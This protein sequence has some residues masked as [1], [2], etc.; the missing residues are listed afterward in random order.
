MNNFNFYNPTKIVFGKDTI[1]TI[2]REIKSYDLK[3]I[4]ILAG[5]GSIKENGVYKEVI[6]ALKNEQIEWLELWG[7]Q[8]NPVMS[9]TL[10]AIEIAKINHAEAVLAIGG[11]SVI[12]EAKAIA[13]GVYLKNFWDAF[14]WKVPIK[15]ALPIFSILTLSGTGSEMNPF[16]VITNEGEFKKWN[17]GSTEI[18]PKVSI[19]DP[20]VQMSLPWHQTVNGA[21]DAL[22]HVMENYFMATD[23]EAVMSVNEAI[24]RSI[25]NSVDKLQFNQKDYNSRANLAW[26][27]TLALNGISGIAMRGG[28]WASHRIEHSISALFPKVAHGAGLAV[29]YPAWIKFV[30]NNKP[31]LFNRWAKNVWNANSVNE[32]IENMKAKF[33]AWKAPTSLKEFGI[34]EKD[35]NQIV[36]NTILFGSIGAIQQL[37]IDDIATILNYAM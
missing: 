18:F 5:G 30:N 20:S 33:A 31:K 4:L 36:Q 32:G 8:P 22:T 34:S 6:T 24:M 10:N 17:I 3:K 13:A 2:G 1:P 26:C 28:D 25:I 27:A 19:I 21:I 16:A 14:E 23:E 15:K 37:D 29:I 9:H 11:G 7:V 12:D 35:M